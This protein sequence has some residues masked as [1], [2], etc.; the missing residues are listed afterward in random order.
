MSTKIDIRGRVLKAT[1]VDVQGL[2]VVTSVYVDKSRHSFVALYIFSTGN[3][4]KKFIQHPK[5]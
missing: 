2:S 4:V 3:E 5:S 1:K